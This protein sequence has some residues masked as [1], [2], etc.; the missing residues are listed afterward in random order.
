M[1]LKFCCLTFNV[2]KC[3]T[4]KKYHFEQIIL[5]HEVH[6]FQFDGLLQIV[7]NS[8]LHILKIVTLKLIYYCKMNNT[9]FCV[10]MQ[11]NCKHNATIET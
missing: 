5:R 6:Q 9:N 10:Q 1:E 8:I 3:R 7:L 2:F 11:T 4:S